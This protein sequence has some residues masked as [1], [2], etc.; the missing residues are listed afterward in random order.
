[1]C[2]VAK[3][4][5]SNYIAYFE[6]DLQAWDLSAAVIIVRNSGGFVTDLE[7]ND[8]DPISHKGY[9]VA[10]ANEKVRDSFL[11]MMRGL[12]NY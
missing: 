9:I 7:G 3:G 4:A 8:I 2:M 12:N 6:Y 5:F 11:E 10:S 1:M